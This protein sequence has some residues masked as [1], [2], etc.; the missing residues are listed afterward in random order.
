[1]IPHNLV[2]RMS[3]TAQTGVRGVDVANGWT[4]SSS[5]KFKEL[6]LIIMSYGI[7]E[8]DQILQE[9][10]I[11]AVLRILGQ[12][13]GAERRD[14]KTRRILLD[15][16]QVRVPT[17]YPPVTRDCGDELRL[18]V[19]R[20]TR[21]AHQFDGGQVKQ[22]SDETLK[23]RDNPQYESLVQLLRTRLGR[24]A[25]PGTWP[26]VADDGVRATKL[27]HIRQP[28]RAPVCERWRSSV[29]RH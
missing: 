7:P 18:I 24:A 2:Q 11:A 4:G 1:M 28:G 10:G 14:A 22:V 3:V 17:I 8:L 16:I 23:F 5:P 29:G 6:V 12:E 13:L 20:T 25:G 27:V 19:G 9:V 21:A 26:N 15:G